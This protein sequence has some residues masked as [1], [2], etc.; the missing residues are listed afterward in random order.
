MPAGNSASPHA[1]RHS[2]KPRRDI[3]YSL[4]VAVTALLDAGSPCSSRADPG[5]RVRRKQD[6]DVGRAFRDIDA[7][8]ADTLR[9]SDDDV[10][11]SVEVPVERA[12]RVAT[13]DLNGRLD[14]GA[15][16]TGPND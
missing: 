3:S 14:D 13:R 8:T 9:H 7:V 1:P 16:R 5:E 2:S 10:L 15:R 12:S 11:L 6:L 4:R